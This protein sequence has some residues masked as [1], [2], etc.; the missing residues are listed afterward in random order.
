LATLGIIAAIEHIRVTLEV[1]DAARIEALH[2]IARLD[3]K[4]LAG[5]IAEMDPLSCSPAVREA[6]A[7][8]LSQLTGQRYQARP[9]VQVGQFVVEA[10][11]DRPSIMAAVQPIVVRVDDD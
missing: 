6:A 3:L 4:P 7:Q 1:T 9:P 11:D 8:V 2:A 10:L 5:R